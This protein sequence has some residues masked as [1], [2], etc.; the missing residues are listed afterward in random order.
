MERP[1]RHIE[2]ERAGDVY[3]ARLRQSRMDE[4]GLYELADELN[5]VA[6]RDD[7]LKLVLSL[8]PETPEFL[9]S[10]FLAK[11][12]ALQRRFRA[13]GGKLKLAD[14]SEETVRVFDVCHLTPLF[15]FAPDRASA[16]EGF[17]T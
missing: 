16:V 11:L 1:Y 14:L 4:D 6:A 2:V 12:V 13:R 10:V 7:C 15:D 8:G 3:C 5:D 17:R 9:Y